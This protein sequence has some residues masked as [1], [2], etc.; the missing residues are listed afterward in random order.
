MTVGTEPTTTLSPEAFNKLHTVSTATL[1]TQLL[2]RGYRNT[3]LQGVSPVDPETRMVGYAFTLRFVPAREDFADTM[4]DNTQNVQRIAVE[5]IGKDQP[6]PD[7]QLNVFLLGRHMGPHH[8][9]QAVAVGDRD[10]GVAQCASRP[11]Q[12]FRVRGAAQEAEIAGA[13]QFGVVCN[14]HS[15]NIYSSCGYSQV[16]WL[17]GGVI[18]VAVRAERINNYELT[19]VKSKPLQGCHNCVAKLG[20]NAICGS[21]TSLARCLQ[22]YW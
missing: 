2:N 16:P 8:P 21:T 14:G 12:L 4:Y 19:L 9:G 17:A 5:A 18:V 22:G 11:H 20:I 15:V 3:F 1:T 10:G 13:E 7:Q 6:R